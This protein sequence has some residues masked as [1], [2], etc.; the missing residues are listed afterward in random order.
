MLATR[1]EG[2]ILAVG[3]SGILQK[4]PRMTHAALGIF[5]DAALDLSTRAFRVRTLLVIDRTKPQSP[6][7]V[8]VYVSKDSVYAAWA[9]TVPAGKR[10]RCPSPHSSMFTDMNDILAT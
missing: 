7:A 8:F 4:I 5:P 1:H 6:C 3:D 10:K 9:G 2:R